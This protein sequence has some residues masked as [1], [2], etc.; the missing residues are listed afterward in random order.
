MKPYP[1]L[2]AFILMI[3]LPAAALAIDY[4]AQDTVISVSPVVR[5]YPVTKIGN[6]STPAIFTVTNLSGGVITINSVTL[7]GT[8]PGDFHLIGGGCTGPLAAASSCNISVS[9]KPTETGTKSAL[10]QI[11]SSGS[12][13]TPTL[14]AYL[15]NSAAAVVEAQQRMPATLAAVT[16]P[17][18]MTVGANSDLSWTI[19]GYDDSYKSYVVMFDCTGVPAGTCGDRYSDATRFVESLELDPAPPTAGDW[20]YSGVVTK[21]FA[22]TWG[23]TPTTGKGPFAP[24]PGTEVVVRFYLKTADD[25]ARGLPG[26]SLLI[27]GDP[28]LSGRYYDTAGRRITTHIIGP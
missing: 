14:T 3:L 16:I 8:N 25:A 13:G 11:A 17:E 19:E 20:G 28:I 18:T 6:E 10:L 1:Y 22:Y 4:S 24:G 21:K 9:F 26:V 7:A 27:P 23:F 12:S 5:Q 2:I 15:T